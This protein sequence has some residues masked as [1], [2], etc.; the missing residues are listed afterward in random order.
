MKRIGSLLQGAEMHF[1]DASLHDMPEAITRGIYISIPTLLTLEPET[2]VSHAAES[3]VS[4]CGHGHASALLSPSRSWDRPSRGHPITS[5]EAFFL[6]IFA[7][8]LEK[9]IF[10]CAQLLPLL[11]CVRGA[12]RLATLVDLVVRVY[13]KCHIDSD[14]GTS[15]VTYCPVRRPYKMFKA[16]FLAL[17][18]RRSRPTWRWSLAPQSA[19]RE[20]S[21]HR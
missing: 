10:R 3:C 12:S 4:S 21:A 20:A 18:L 11:T 15:A 8:E 1:H 7:S 14:S 16:I 13:L 6:G 5:A 17:A 19:L 2:T 9:S